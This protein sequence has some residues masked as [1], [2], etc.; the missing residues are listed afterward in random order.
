M[1]EKE[2]DRV[3]EQGKRDSDRVT[4]GLERSQVL[5]KFPRIRKNGPN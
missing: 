3:E 1:D 4:M 2:R 5:E